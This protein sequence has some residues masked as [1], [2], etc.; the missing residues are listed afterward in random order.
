MA[1]HPTL[2]PFDTRGDFNDDFQQEIFE[3]FLEGV[4]AAGLDPD[5]AALHTQV[6]TESSETCNWAKVRIREVVNNEITTLKQTARMLGTKM[7]ATT[8]GLR[9]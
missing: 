3:A 8:T 7:A 6:Q 5:S 2:D 9:R 1:N 4:E